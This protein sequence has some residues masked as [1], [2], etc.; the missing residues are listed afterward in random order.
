[1]KGLD[2]NES[3]IIWEVLK[4]AKFNRSIVITSKNFD[5][6]EENVDRIVVLENGIVKCCEDIKNLTYKNGIGYEI[7]LF[8]ED[9]NFPLN[10]SKID[11]IFKSKYPKVIIKDERFLFIN[12][13]S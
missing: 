9:N 3:L 13:K 7:I 2:Y 12:N 1:M 6:V 10:I 11:E 4:E 8:G 5:E